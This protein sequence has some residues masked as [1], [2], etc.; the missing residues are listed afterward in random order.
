MVARSGDGADYVTLENCNRGGDV[1]R[2]VQR[3]YFD[4]YTR[5]KQAI[6]TTLR[7]AE[8][9]D[10]LLAASNLRPK[11]KD[12][13]ATTLRDCLRAIV[14]V[15]TENEGIATAQAKREA[16]EIT[17][18]QGDLRWF[19]KLYGSHKGQSFHE[20][21]AKSGYFVDPITLRVRKPH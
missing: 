16:N 3:L 11:E 4:L 9:A 17:Q 18:T 2:L 8:N 21:M 14:T 10:D 1:D 13:R 15:V 7:D 5:N 12:E 20:Q 19:F 6:L